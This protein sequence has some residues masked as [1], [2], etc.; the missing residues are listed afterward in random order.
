MNMAA[1]DWL[2][3]YLAGFEREHV[4]VH[5]RDAQVL[6]PADRLRLDAEDWGAAARIAAT[7]GLRHAGVFADPP[8]P[9]PADDGE[10]AITVRAVLE[11]QGDYLVLETRVPLERPDLPSQTPWYPGLDRLERH[12]QDLVGLRFVGHPHPHRWTRHQAW[13]DGRFPLRADF[14]LEGDD[15]RRAPADRDYPFE[16]LSGDGVYQIP[17]G[18]VHAGIIEPGHF[19]FHAEGETVL[20]LEARLGYVHK[21]IE[22]L[23]VGRDPAGLARL[24]GRVSGDSTVAH[25]W[26]ACQTLER[27][28][29]CAVPERA[30]ALRGLLCER[31]RLANHIGDIGAICNDVGMAFIHMQ[32]A[33]LR[34]IWQ[35]AS[36]TH[37]GHRLLMDRVVPGGV[38]VD[39]D[40]TA[41]ATLRAEHEALRRLIAPVFAIVDDLPSLADRLL[42]TGQ[43]KM[44]DARALG[45]TGYV[46]KA[47]GLGFDLRR[48]APYSPYD[49]L[50]VEVPVQDEGDV[51]AR[52]RVRMQEV[53]QS[54]ALMDE[55]LQRLPDGPIAADLPPAP[56][57]S[58][59][60]GLIEGW[61]GEVL[62]FVRL[63]ADG[64]IARYFARDP[65]WFSWPALERLIHGNIV[66]DF[67]VC[68]KSING[69]YSGHDL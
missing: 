37:F 5:G 21:G 19:R 52:V 51:A 43:L 57:G 62:A 46:A 45:C 9:A 15:P 22:R 33:R 38:A 20:Q 24:A 68:N 14:A 64:T 63:A 1:F 41:I 53:R 32:C 16:V 17:V 35:R 50:G 29:G 56:A 58:L 10:S 42:S 7:M 31:E 60:L 6:A 55:L 30:L 69:S 48:D 36:R 67:P 3:D 54:L 49:T 39:L 34:E 65:S 25:T 66:P 27:A 8:D 12:A 23:A 26:A 11:H 47:S 59:G 28:S 13:A 4:L 40:A 44:D 61:R 2:S 18:P